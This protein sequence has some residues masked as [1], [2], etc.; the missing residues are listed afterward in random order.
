MKKQIP[1]I[2]FLKNRIPKVG[3][4]MAIFSVD[5]SGNCVVGDQH[6]VQ[7]VDKRVPTIRIINV[8]TGAIKEGECLCIQSPTSIIFIDD[9]LNNRFSQVYSIIELGYKK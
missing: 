8:I 6:I 9:L 2:E 7:V 3:D 5:E 1:R 4:T